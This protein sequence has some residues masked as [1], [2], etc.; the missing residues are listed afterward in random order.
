MARRFVSAGDPAVDKAIQVATAAPASPL[1]GIRLVENVVLVDGVT[2]RI[3]HGLRRKLRGWIVVR[4]STSDALAALHDEQATH[5][6]TDVY[7]YLRANG[8][9]PTVSLL[10]F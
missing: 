10:V 4:T 9:S 5:S 3:S 6:D 8:Y 1:D 7:L 2:K